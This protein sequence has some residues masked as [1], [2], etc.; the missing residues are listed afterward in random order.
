[1][2]NTNKDFSSARKEREDNQASENIASL[3]VIEEQVVISKEVVET[4][5]VHVSKKVTEDEVSIDLPMI[6]E[7]YEVE[8]IAV[9]KRLLNEYPSTRY[10]NGNMV[11]PV[12]REVLV[13]E[14]RYEVSEEVFIK[15]TVKEIPNQ[16]QVIL[17]KESVDITRTSGTQ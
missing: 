4:G 13:V 14:K 10:E 12:V 3:P 17:K 7:G 1:M 5:K 8:R 11:I 6:Q 2:D 15:K 9:E 16:Q